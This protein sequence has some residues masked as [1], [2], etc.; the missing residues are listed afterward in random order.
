[1]K[2]CVIGSGIFGI[3]AVR[4]I[5]RHLP[6]WSVHWVSE[7][8]EAGGLWNTASKRSRVYDTLFLNTS[9][10]RSA[11]TGT[12]IQAEPSVHFVHHSLYSAYLAQVADECHGPQRHWECR[13]DSVSA[14][15]GGG[16]LV[17]WHDRAGAET[18][19]EFDAVVDATGHNV[20]AVWPN[21]PRAAAP[22]YTL[23]HSAE[24]KNAEP[25][26]G[27]RVLV[28]GNGASAVDIAC[29]LITAAS[30]V[31][32]SIRTPKWYLPKVLLGKPIDHSGGGGLS[33]APLVGR[34]VARVGESVVRRVVGSYDSF[35]LEA[36]KSPLAVST[37]VLSDHFL[38]HLSHGRL[39]ARTRV[40]ALE[41]ESVRFA[42]GTEGTFDAVIAATGFQ[43]ASP[44]LPADVRDTLSRHRL[45][46]SLEAP[47]SPGLYLLNRFRCGDSAVACA[48]VQAAAVARSL[49]SSRSRSGAPPDLA[50][51]EVAGRRITARTLRKVYE[52]YR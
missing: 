3:A 24:Y 25:Y 9:R 11:Y 22:A 29:E 21:V 6:E 28:I 16:W 23:S 31:E 30:R 17:R 39:H 2:V 52:A 1:M 35:G 49:P 34:V 45:G 14:R 13:V 38:P 19:E 42:D 46:L 4:E 50:G 15:E 8:P 7:D 12:A 48:E 20:E 26:R 51:P 43:D 18:E 41:Q 32:I 27:K 5:S 10:Q 44:H 36:P 33:H 40:V 37:P 47:G